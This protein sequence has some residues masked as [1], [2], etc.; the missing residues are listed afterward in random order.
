M[1]DVSDKEIRQKLATNIFGKGDE[2]LLFCSL[3]SESALGGGGSRKVDED[4]DGKQRII[5]I[6]S[7]L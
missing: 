4:D 1:A 6:S 7:T 2:K 3:V 5:C